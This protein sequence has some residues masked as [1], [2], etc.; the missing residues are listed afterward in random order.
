MTTSPGSATTPRTRQDRWVY[1]WTGDVLL[2]SVALPSLEVALEEF[3]SRG[4]GLCILDEEPHIAYIRPGHPNSV[5]NPEKMTRR[6][7]ERSG[8]TREGKWE[9]KEME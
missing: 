2:G 4:G 5:A 9:I 8:R 1:C 3:D 7:L 6:M